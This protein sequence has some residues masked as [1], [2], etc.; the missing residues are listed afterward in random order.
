[1]SAQA[2]LT[3]G[4]VPLNDAAPL[5]VALERGFFAAEGLEVSLSREVSWATVRDKVAAGA[6]EG[7][8]MLAPIALAC[9]L[10]LGLGGD[11]QPMI[12]PMAL[13]RGGAAFTLARRLSMAFKAGEPRAAG[14]ARVIAERRAAG[15][16]QPIF[17]VVFPYSMHNYLLRYWLAEAGVDPDRDLR[18]TVAPPS[19]MASRLAAGELDGFCAGEPW[20]AV[21]EDQGVGE[22]AVR[23]FE[24]W[25]DGPEKVL[26]VKAEWANRNPDILQ[27]LLR[28]LLKAAAWADDPENC[29]SLAR[30]LARPEYVDADPDSIARSLP[31]TRFHQD[32]AGAPLPVHAAWQL[33]QMIRWG[34]APREIDIRAVAERVCR[35]DL[36]NQAA[37]SLGRAPVE[38]PET[39]EGFAD[40][41]VFRLGEA[42]AYAESFPL[43]R[44]TRA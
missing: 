8:H 42:R 33:S 26:G 14:L 29:G 31:T 13:N 44:L 4:F 12:A 6:L 1:L 21:A 37:A 15:D 5:I 39:A 38:P 25:R 2:R 7:A 3:L 41:R 20:N 30:L 23:A 22:V 36:Y 19:R 18:I 10:G 28:A 9:T 35:L 40:G 34:Q 17:A 27:A 24:I 32:A 16:P 43:S 11:P